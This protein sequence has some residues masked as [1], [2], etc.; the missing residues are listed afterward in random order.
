MSLEMLA[1]LSLAGIS[2]AYSVGLIHSYYGSVNK[3]LSHYE[4][5][6]FVQSINTAVLGGYGSVNLY[7]P[8]GMCNA[9]VNGDELNTLYGRFYFVRYVTISKGVLCSYGNALAYLSYN[10]SLV[11]VTQ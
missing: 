4:Y 7:V 9:T 1:Y 3:S 11:S 10:Q 5:Y 6:G 8:E 2:M